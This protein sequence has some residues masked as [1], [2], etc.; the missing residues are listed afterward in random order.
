MPPVRN[1]FT[2]ESLSRLQKLCRAQ[3]STS[4]EHL[5]AWGGKGG[6][7]VSAV[8]GGS[9][10]QHSRPLS[11]LLAPLC[12]PYAPAPL[13]PHTPAHL[14]CARDPPRAAGPRLAPPALALVAGS[15]VGAAAA[16]RAAC[17]AA[18]AL[19][20]HRVHP[21]RGAEAALVGVGRTAASRGPRQKNAGVK[22]R[23]GSAREQLAGRQGHAETHSRRYSPTDA[24]VGGMRACL[25][26]SGSVQGTQ[27]PPL[28]PKPKLQLRQAPVLPSQDAHSGVLSWH[29]GR[30]S[31]GA[32]TQLL[33]A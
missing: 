5:H 2:L 27:A 21:T 15:L 23:A 18:H 12:M 31:G 16:W 20:R 24:G 6:A 32:G 29:C 4:L 11:A 28:I 33:H 22:L 13:P 7:A 3:Q 1:D 30:G 9:S 14:C 26:Q 25:T 8:G 10:A 19:P 17:R